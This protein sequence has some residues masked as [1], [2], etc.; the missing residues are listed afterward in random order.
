SALRVANDIRTHEP[1]I[2]IHL[3]DVYYSGTPEEF[4]RYFL[5]AEDWPR[6]TDKTF[7]LNSNHEMYSGG[8]GYFGVALPAFRQE[9]SFFCLENPHWRIVAVDTGY[10]ARTFPLLELLL[11]GLIR[12]HDENKKWLRDVVFADPR[13]RRPVILLGHHPAFSAFD[14][15]YPRLLDDLSAYLDRV[16]LWFWAH[17]HRFAAYAPHSLGG[18]PVVP[19]PVIWHGP[20]PTQL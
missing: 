3:G 1:E 19:P 14:T 13:D 15:E 8:A 6:G 10:Y 18:A 7:V 20:M 2:T 11:S 12:L 4:Q 5:G 16:L 9:A 17:E